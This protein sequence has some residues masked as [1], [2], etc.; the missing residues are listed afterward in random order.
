MYVVVNVKTHCNFDNHVDIIL[1]KAVVASIR[2]F[3]N[4]GFVALQARTEAKKKFDL[5]DIPRLRYYLRT[6]IYAAMRESKFE[7]FYYP[8]DSRLFP[9]YYEVIEYPMSL[10]Q[11]S[12]FGRVFFIISLLHLLKARTKCNIH[13][14][15][16]GEVSWV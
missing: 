12:H 14:V 4:E 1:L 10:Q 5:N 9:E 15:G 13:D 3:V 11:V 2:D 6:V 7:P 8:V 16:E